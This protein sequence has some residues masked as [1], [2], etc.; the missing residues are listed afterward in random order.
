MLAALARRPGAHRRMVVTSSKGGTAAEDNKAARR[1]RARL[2]DR[3]RTRP[4]VVLRRI[5]DQHMLV[6]VSRSL[7]HDI[8]VWVLNDTGALIWSLIGD[9]T[10]M[11]ELASKVGRMLARPCQGLRNDVRAF[12]TA[13]ASE[14]LVEPLL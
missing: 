7:S 4:S 10:D 1:A 5:G 6:P 14:G 3:Y 13:L 9:G 11:E 2:S 8:Y 12:V